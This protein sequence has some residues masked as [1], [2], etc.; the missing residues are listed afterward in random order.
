MREVA[1]EAGVSLRLVQYYFH[2]KEELL[3]G[4]L[5]H[6]GERIGRRV[7]D[8]VAALT[9]P[10]APAAY[11]RAMLGA[12]IPHDEDGRQVMLAYTAHFTLT[13]SQPHLAPEGLAQAEALRG[14][15][16]GRF[17][18]ARDSGHLAAAGDPETLAATALALV[19]GLQLSVLA[20]QHPAAHATSLLNAHLDHLFAPSA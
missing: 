17:Q 11:L 10:V 9:E 4:V 12:L 14:S 15:V 7:Q 19:T 18:Q 8:A 20:N 3:S 16:A 13:L 5:G 6:L 2:T 1:A